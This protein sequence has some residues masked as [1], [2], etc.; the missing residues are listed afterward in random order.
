MPSSHFF[1]RVHEGVNFSVTIQFEQKASL[2]IV[3][4]RLQKRGNRSV[5]VFSRKIIQ[6]VKTSYKDHRISRQSPFF[7]RRRNT[8]GQSYRLGR[9]KR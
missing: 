7:T 5:R 3:I 1:E 9:A 4:E 6:R 8:V 2:G